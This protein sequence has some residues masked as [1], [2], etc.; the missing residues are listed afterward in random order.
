MA[1]GDH[2]QRACTSTAA[3]Q[4]RRRGVRP[5][6]ASS[7]QWHPRVV[8]RAVGVCAVPRITVLSLP[9]FPFPVSRPPPAWFSGVTS[10]TRRSTVRA[11][12]WSRA[13]A[14]GAQPARPRGGARLP[15]RPRS[16]TPRASGGPGEPK[17]NIAVTHGV[18][19]HTARHRTNHH[20]AH[21]LS[22]LWYW[23]SELLLLVQPELS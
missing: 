12:R 1:A 10:T 17:R 7:R 3:E 6:R 13:A 20:D 16:H 23:R 21:A 5:T 11:R 19:V 22:A 2:A 14:A 18:C 9:P 4:R 8:W 15:R